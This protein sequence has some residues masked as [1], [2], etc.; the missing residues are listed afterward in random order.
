MHLDAHHAL[1]GKLGNALQ[2]VA[3]RIAV[4]HYRNRLILREHGRIVG[5]V[6]RHLPRGQHFVRNFEEQA[7]VVMSER[8]HAI[9]ERREQ[10]HKRGKSLLRNQHLCGS[11]DTWERPINLQIAK[12][13]PIGGNH[14]DSFGADLKL[15]PTQGVAAL[16]V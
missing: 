16:L 8:H 15:R 6:P 11:S 14:R 9:L 2:R 10:G 5:K 12:P 1:V 13:M 7:V 3:K 4:D